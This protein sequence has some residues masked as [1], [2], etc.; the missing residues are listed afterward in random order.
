MQYEAFMYSL[1]LCIYV[2]Y[3][4]IF[5]IHPSFYYTFVRVKLYFRS[6]TINFLKIKVSCNFVY[7]LVV[8]RGSAREVHDMNINL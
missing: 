3:Y 6:L 4:K 2:L 7:R 5:Y 1:F 8:V